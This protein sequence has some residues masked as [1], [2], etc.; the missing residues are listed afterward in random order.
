MS[1]IPYEPKGRFYEVV[2][3]ALWPERTFLHSLNQSPFCN[4]IDL[5]MWGKNWGCCVEF[6]EKASYKCNTYIKGNTKINRI[7]CKDSKKALNKHMKKR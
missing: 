1:G 3:V 6:I 5:W 4:P 7:E 2:R